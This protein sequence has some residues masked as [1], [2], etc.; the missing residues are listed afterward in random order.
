MNTSITIQKVYRGMVKKVGFYLGNIYCEIPITDIEPLPSIT[1]IDDTI[2]TYGESNMESFIYEKKTA[3]YLSEYIIWW[4]S[5]YLFSSG[6]EL[7]EES[8][9]TFIKKKTSLV[10]GHIYGNIE[11]FFSFKN[12]IINN[13]KFIFSN[14]EIKK[15]LI[16]VLK[17]YTLRDPKGV[18]DYHK[19]DSIL[20]YYLDI[21]DFEKHEGQILL[22]GEDSVDKLIHQGRITYKLE[23]EVKPQYNIP[24]FFQNDIL[25]KDIYIAYNCESLKIGV[26]VCVNWYKNGFVPDF[27]EKKK[28]K[29]TVYFYKYISE[30]NIEEYVIEGEPYFQKI[31]VLGYKIDDTPKFT[32]L[33]KL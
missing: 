33:L 28:I 27:P 19:R 11:K 24:Y 18:I 1:I 21:T 16:Y 26:D 2:E 8:L 13:D 7:T 31:M 25:G 29:Y 5:K 12:T 20:N 15:R 9:N 17:L 30:D 14:E 32:S 23:H 22:Q 3:R 10:E 6:E 4:Y